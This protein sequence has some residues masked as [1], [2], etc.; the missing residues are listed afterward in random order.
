MDMVKKKHGIVMEDHKVK[1]CEI[2]ESVGIST[3]LVHNILHET[4][5]MEKTECETGALIVDSRPKT[6]VKDI[7]TQWLAMLNHNPQDFW[8]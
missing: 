8:R 5:H 4:L 3:E 7:S 1:V 2:A 6:H